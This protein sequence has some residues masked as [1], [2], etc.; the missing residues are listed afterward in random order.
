MAVER[1]GAVCAVRSQCGCVP[2]HSS[3][4]L[5]R[6]SAEQTRC[7][8]GSLVANL[9]PSKLQQGGLAGHP[10]SNFLDSF[11][12]I[13]HMILGVFEALSKK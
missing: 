5:A 12:L 6:A 11:I 1:A 3:V 4:F 2:S 9:S 10:P 8:E 7:K 13:V